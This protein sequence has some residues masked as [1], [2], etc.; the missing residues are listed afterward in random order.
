MSNAAHWQHARPG[1]WNDPDYLLIGWVGDAH[2][3]AEG[4]PTTLSPDEQYS[5]MSMWCLMASPLIFSGDMAKLDEFTLN[6]LCAPEL[7]DINQDPLGKQA[8][9]IKRDAR[10]FVLAKPLEDG[11]MAV[12]LF[13]LT[14]EP[15]R[16]EVPLGDLRLKQGVRV[17][18]AWR[19][20]DLPDATD[21]LVA[22]IPPHGVAVFR[23]TPKPGKSE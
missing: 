13:N 22:E 4:K 5:Y 8:E 17:R 1:A 20:T 3:M 9:I 23:L 7:I 19:Q 15:Q 14:N 12:G 21:T 2:G 18:D 11:S 6:V 16:L 10:Q